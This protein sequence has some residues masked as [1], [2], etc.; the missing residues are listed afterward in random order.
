MG[1]II[2]FWSRGEIL[3]SDIL[4]VTEVEWTQKKVTNTL[5]R[6]IQRREIRIF[7]NVVSEICFTLT[8]TDQEPSEKDINTLMLYFLSIEGIKDLCYN[9]GEIE[10]RDWLIKQIFSIVWNYMGVPEEETNAN[11]EK[12]WRKNK[13]IALIKELFRKH[14]AKKDCFQTSST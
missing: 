1:K 3:N 14:W 2:D 4:P 7:F 8:N 5:C 9:D 13:K 10:I 12:D 6:D 11:P